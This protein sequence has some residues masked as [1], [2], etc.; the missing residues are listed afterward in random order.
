MGSGS[1]FEGCNLLYLF[2]DFVL[3]REQRELR[4]GT[5]LFPFS[6]GLR[7][8]G[9]PRRNRASRVS[10]DD[11]LAAVWADGSCRNRR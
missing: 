10:K 7:P 11:I 3:D 6:P 2:E 8:F 4:R 5:R 9:V 1:T